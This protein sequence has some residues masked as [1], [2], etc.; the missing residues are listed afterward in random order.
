MRLPGEISECE[1]RVR[2]LKQVWRRTDDS[3]WDELLRAYKSAKALLR[4]RRCDYAQEVDIRI[5]EEVIKR[6]G[7]DE[8]L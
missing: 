7:W 3:N 8:Y 6:E 1:K 4:L 5:I 2:R